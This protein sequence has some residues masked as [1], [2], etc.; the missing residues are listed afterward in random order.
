MGQALVLAAPRQIV[1]ETFQD[2]ALKPEEVRLQTLYSGLSAGTE[3]SQY[4]ATS[5]YMNKL[6]D[7]SRRL[8][9]GGAGVSW[10]YPV[11]NL[12]YEE[13]GR[14]VEVGA[15]VTGIPLG[16]HVFGTWSHRTHYVA[17]A[18]WVR[19]RLMPAG[20]DPRIGIFSH[21]GAVGLNSVHDGRIRIGETVAVFGLGTVG[22]IVAQA[23]RKSGARVIVVDLL[24]TR[25]EMARALGAHIL[26]NPRRDKPAEAIKDLTGGRGADVCFEASGSTI[27]LNEAIRAVA[28]SSRVVALGFYQGQARGLELGDEFHHNRIN[29]VGSQISGSDPE[30]KYRWD[31]MRLWQTAIRLHAEGTLNLIP[32]I[33]HTVPFERA[34]ELFALLDKGPEDVI[35]AVLE[36]KNS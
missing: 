14:V 10:E 36:F 35:Q 28:Y 25:L 5:P 6:W 15:A 12:G 33:T 30:L 1:Y 9:L 31:K 13:V 20:A 11:R 4:R 18:E 22:Q 19:Q 21:I 24:D 26:L 23:A 2:V 27:A 32:L 34:P 17:N 16:A 29:I 8:Y 7:E 3:L